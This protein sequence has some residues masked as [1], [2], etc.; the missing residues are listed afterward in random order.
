MYICIGVYIYR[1]GERER[2]PR[3]RAVEAELRLAMPRD[4]P[5]RR[6]RERGDA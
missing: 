6:A 3:N 4:S 5:R 2:E 1:E